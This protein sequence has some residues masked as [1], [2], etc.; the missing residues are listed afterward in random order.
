MSS[1]GSVSV[2]RSDR[3]LSIDARVGYRTRMASVRALRVV[4]ITMVLLLWASQAQA[5][6]SS[7]WT[8]P[9]N[10]LWVLP[11]YGHIRA[12]ERFD[13]NGNVANFTD[14]DP[15]GFY[16]DESLYANV[17]FGLTDG[18]TL[19]LELPYKFVEVQESPSQPVPSEKFT[20]AFGNLY[21]G[22]RFGVLDLLP[23]ETRL[24]WSIEIGAF[25]PMGY[26]RNFQPSVGPGNIDFD[27]KTALGYGFTIADVLPSYTQ[28]G[29][30]FRARSTAFALSRAVP[31]STGDPTCL[32]DTKPRY[33]DEF[34]FLGEY[35]VTP[36][37]GAVLGFLKV[38]GTVSLLEPEVAFTATNP[39]P[40]RQRYLKVG[41]GGLVYP[42]RFFGV[43]YGENVGLMVQYFST[44]WGQNTTKSDDLFVGF[45][46]T[47]N[48]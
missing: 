13:E 36:F 16:T 15:A 39:I 47:H 3:T 27:V 14:V 41:G 30:G 44:V 4:G 42:L 12:G 10:Q 43:K 32:L 18:L 34:I 37:K 48:F 17:E 29:M 6:N 40:A 11:F 45:E 24:E 7:A 28:V 20:R 22:L 2:L 21:A 9:K 25:L 31:C 38:M 1:R 35:G 33:G 5:F 46:Y 23:V 19:H 26:T 8:R